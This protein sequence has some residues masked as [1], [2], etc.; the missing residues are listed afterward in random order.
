MHCMEILC[1]CQRLM[2]GAQ[3]VN[4]ELYDH[5][6]L[7]RQLLRKIIKICRLNPLYCWKKINGNA[8]F[9]KM[10]WIAILWKQQQLSCKTSSVTALSGTAFGHHDHQ[11]LRHLISFCR[12]FLKKDSTATMQEAWW[13]L[14]ITLQALA[15]WTTNSLR[16][17]TVKS[18]NA[19]LQ[20][21]WGGIFN[22]CCNNRVPHYWY[23]LKN[24]NK[25]KRYSVL[26]CIL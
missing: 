10:G 7:K 2:L 12:D 25:I 18:M 3:C 1:I 24:K 5:C 11:T 6:F 15:D 21:E 22:T 16:G 8:G 14:N 19:Y 4:N 9:S 20:E 13:T 17:G 23:L 26:G